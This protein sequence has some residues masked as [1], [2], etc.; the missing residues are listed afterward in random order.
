MLHPSSR[1]ILTTLIVLGA[2]S[3][4]FLVSKERDVFG[5]LKST[6]LIGR[7]E[8]GAYLV[9]TNQLVRAWEQQSPM[10]GRPVEAA[11]DTRKKLLA[12]LNNSAVHLL[13]GSTGAE[14]ARIPSRST[15]YTG[16]AFRP[17]DR[18][19]WASEA[20]RKGPDSILITSLTELGLPEGTSRITFPGHPVPTGIAFSQDGATAWIALSNNN[21]VAVV[22]TET[23]KVVREIP[24]GMAPFGIAVSHKRKQVY[25]SNRGGR[26]P[27]SQD[28][29]AGSSTSEVITNAAT[30]STASGTIS[31]IDMDTSPNG[32]SLWDSRPRALR[33][34]RTTVCWPVRFPE[35]IS[36]A[37]SQFPGC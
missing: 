25:V 24:V 32:P 10:R 33:F 11:F 26:R 13:D 7:Q 4:A 34:L 28:V 19:L 31:V 2:A 6:A 29:T 27:A 20:T 16:L 9:A 18:E 3:T 1:Q 5:V 36:P 17:G 23:R 37:Q 21:S 35:A 22:D 8:S 30:G 12:V 15:S 14:I